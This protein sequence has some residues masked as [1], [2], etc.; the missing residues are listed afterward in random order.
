MQSELRSS[1]WQPDKYGHSSFVDCPPLPSLSLPFLKNAFPELLH[2]F[3][4]Q[5]TKG[6]QNL[7]EGLWFSGSYLGKVR[8]KKS[9]GKISSEKKTTAPLEKKSNTNIRH[10]Y[11]N[12]PL[13]KNNP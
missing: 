2:S 10:E 7:L 13:N 11:T 9:L 6:N 12:M 4:S 5:A 1:H 8:E 3:C